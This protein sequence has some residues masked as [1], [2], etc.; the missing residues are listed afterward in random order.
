[1][2]DIEFEISDSESGFCDFEPEFLD[3]GFVISEWQARTMMSNKEPGA[4]AEH[5]VLLV[6]LFRERGVVDVL[7][8]HAGLCG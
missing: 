5:I 3:F 1:L 8:D 6:A 2:S 4:Q 7:V